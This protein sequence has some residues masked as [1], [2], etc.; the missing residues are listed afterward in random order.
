MKAL[1]SITIDTKIAKKIKQLKQQYPDEF[2]SESSLIERAV[3][4]FIEK[5][6]EDK[7]EN[8]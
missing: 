6:E 4:E 5:I 8:T 7:N 1:K 3:K 2:K